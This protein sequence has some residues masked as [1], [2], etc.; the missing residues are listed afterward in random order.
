MKNA[1]KPSD[2]R[3]DARASSGDAGDRGTD[4]G[5]QAESPR[6]I[7]ARGWKDVLWRVRHEV[8]ADN[9]GLIAAAVAFF[10]MLSIF[11]TLIAA[12]SIYGLL[13][14]PAQVQQ[15]IESLSGIL[16]AEARDVLVQQLHSIVTRTTTVLRWSAVVAAAGAL[17]SASSG[18][19]KL[20]KAIGI[21]YDEPEERGFIKQ[22]ALALLLTLGFI[23][24]G[25]LA[26]GAIAVLPALLGHIG[27]G[28][29]GGAIVEYG[30]W[31][32][33][34]LLAMVGLAVLYD[35]APHRDRPRWRW[36]TWGSVVATVIWIVASIGFSI[37]V[38]NFGSFGETYGALAGVIVLMLWMF[39]SAYVILLGAELNSEMEAQTARDSTVGQTEPMGQRGAQKADTLGEARE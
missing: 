14:S 21:A 31:P 16:P 10:A 13:V 12:I 17:W 9:M 27:L 38:R 24:A 20:M 30:R 39:V 18:T 36:V 29:V 19:E 26:L 22:R 4:R 1:E 15:Q 7:P 25:F 5:R 3:R 28:A 11:P 8:A 32:V 6:D 23:T 34:A 37:Y 2:R 33:L 35:V